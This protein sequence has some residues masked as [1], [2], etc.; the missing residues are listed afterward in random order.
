MEYSSHPLDGPNNP[1]TSFP[2]TPPPKRASRK[3]PPPLELLDQFVDSSI[4]PA[5]K[6]TEP[7]A[8]KPKGKSRKKGHGRSKS[9]QTWA[10][11]DPAWRQQLDLGI[12]RLQTDNGKLTGRPMVRKWKRRG[13]ISLLFKNTA[14]TA[15]TTIAFDQIEYYGTKEAI[16]CLEEGFPH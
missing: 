12:L 8:E 13:T 9:A 6:I 1:S 14:K 16:L 5:I 4:P 15:T 7:E 10:T 11:A 2:S 3:I